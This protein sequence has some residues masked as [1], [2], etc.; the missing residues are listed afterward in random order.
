MKNIAIIFGTSSLEHKV[1]IK[2]AK[3]LSIE[4]PKLN[5]YNLYYIGITKNNIWKYSN[6]INNIIDENTLS[7]INDCDNIF[8]IGDGKIN[9]IIIDC[10]LLVTHGKIGEDGTIQGYLTINKIPY[11][12]SNVDSS[13]Y[14]LN[15]HISKYIANINN[16]ESVPFVYIKKSM[17]NKLNII[18]KIKHLGDKFVVKINNSGSSI[19][20]FCCNLITIYDTIDEAFT[21]SDAIIIEKYLNIR[22]LSIGII[23]DG[24]K[25]I[26][27]DIG[28]VICKKDLW[29]LQNKFESSG[30]ST[31]I[32]IDID[33]NIKDEIIK[34]ATILFEQLNLK[35]YTRIDFF[36]VDNKIYFNEVNTLPGLS[37]SSVIIKIFSKIY[38]YRNLINTIIVNYLKNN[39]E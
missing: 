31:F 13:C 2:S 30:G 28:E 8:Q 15:K 25:L 24:D 21:L 23:Q 26:Y 22:E 19:G 17:Y 27:S 16:V 18:E 4:L 39:K 32:D 35:D 5:L 29:N 37:G 34:K 7:I 38:N 20:T 3:T 9:N 11:I 6:D 14:C 36:L 1:S 10:A 33:T 12:G